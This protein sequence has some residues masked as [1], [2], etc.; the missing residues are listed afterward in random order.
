MGK[1]AV[2]VRKEPR[3]WNPIEI[4]QHLLK[5]KIQK[6]SLAKENWL[7]RKESSWMSLVDSTLQILVWSHLCYPWPKEGQESTESK[8]YWGTVVFAA[9]QK[10]N[11]PQKNEM[12]AS[13]YFTACSACTNSAVSTHR[14]K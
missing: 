5:D 14:Q 4:K 1:L 2:G 10:S 11:G 3:D 8:T 7:L 13:D 12:N 9:T 6:E